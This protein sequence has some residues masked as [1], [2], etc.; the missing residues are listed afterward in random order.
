MPKPKKKAVAAKP[1]VI[2][3]V[4][5]THPGFKGE[6]QRAV[7]LAHTEGFGEG[8]HALLFHT[9]SKTNGGFIILAHAY[10][11]DNGSY[12]YEH[13]KQSENGFATN[14]KAT[15]EAALRRIFFK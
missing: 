4:Q 2:V 10:L 3:E 11:Q 5:T 9:R 8:R 14:L 1:G 15:D 6:V 12:K 7:L 13:M